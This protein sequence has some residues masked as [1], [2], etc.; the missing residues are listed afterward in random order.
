M[1]PDNIGMEETKI[2]A[3]QYTCKIMPFVFNNGNFKLDVEGD[4]GCSHLSV[5]Q[6]GQEDGSYLY[7]NH[8]GQQWVGFP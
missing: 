3:Q 5:Y 8:I 7:D 4:M 6:E 1:L 2:S